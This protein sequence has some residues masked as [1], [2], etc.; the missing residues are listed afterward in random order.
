MSMGTEAGR[1]TYNEANLIKK[2][3]QNRKTL[4]L[5]CLSRWT[6]RWI[7]QCVTPDDKKHFFSTFAFL[8]K[9]VNGEAEFVTWAWF[10]PQWKT[11]VFSWCPLGTGNVLVFSRSSQGI[12]GV[13]CSLSSVHGD[14]HVIHRIEVQVSN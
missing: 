11:V 12:P 5:D 3:K 4:K 8:R 2:K 9:C 10:S 13:R 6:L 1:K 7:K 14:A